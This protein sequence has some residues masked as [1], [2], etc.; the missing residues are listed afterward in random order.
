MVPPH[1]ACAPW[2]LLS[3]HQNARKFFC[4]LEGHLAV[5]RAVE[6]SDN[7]QADPADA[8][9]ERSVQ[10][11]V[12]L[13]PWRDSKPHRYGR[14]IAQQEQPSHTGRNAPEPARRGPPCPEVPPIGPN[15]NAIRTS[16]I[17]CPFV[18]LEVSEF[19]TYVTP[20][21]SLV[22]RDIGH[23][24]CHVEASGHCVEDRR[25]TAHRRAGRH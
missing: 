8:P 6:V 22:S 24:R 11:S 9:H 25:E 14:H 2:H 3:H 15:G 16:R 7:A 19:R 20:D 12:H 23:S 5:P 1:R 4:L 21:K 17:A 10:R 13:C 18:P